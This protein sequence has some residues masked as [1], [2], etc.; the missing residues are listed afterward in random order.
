MSEPPSSAVPPDAI[1]I[2]DNAYMIPIGKD[3]TGCMRYR[4]HAPGRGVPQVIYYADGKGGFT[5]SRDAAADCP[6]VK[7]PAEPKG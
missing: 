7:P 5:M 3:D 2:G 4:M 1:E 6:P